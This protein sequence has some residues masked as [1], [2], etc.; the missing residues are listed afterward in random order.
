MAEERAL[1]TRVRDFLSRIPLPVRIGGT[2]LFAAAP[3]EAATTP[4][5]IT[6][7]SLGA[8]TEIVI[9][10]VKEGLIQAEGEHALA[11]TTAVLDL[12]QLS[13]ADGVE[14][15]VQTEAPRNYED[16]MRLVHRH[17]PGL[18]NP[19][20]L[21]AR[22]G[23][24]VIRAQLVE[25]DR[26]STPLGLYDLTNPGIDAAEAKRVGG[27]HDGA[28][29]A[30]RNAMADLLTSLEGKENR[31]YKDHNGHP[32]IGKGFNLDAQGAAQ[33]WA[34][35]FN[36]AAYKKAMG[37]NWR[38]PDFDKAKT[39]GYITN[40]EVRQ[41]TSHVLKEKAGRMEYILKTRYDID[42]DQLPA[43][44]RVGLWMMHYHREDYIF[45]G[46]KASGL[47][48]EIKTAL[49]ILSHPD[50]YTPGAYD[51]AR[52]DLGDVYVDQ[53]ASR[54]DAGPLLPRAL[55][56]KA[57]IAG[58]AD[59]SLNADQV[60]AAIQ[61]TYAKDAGDARAVVILGESPI[62]ASGSG[63]DLCDL[64]QGSPIDI[65]HS[66]SKD[67]MTKLYAR[68][69]GGG[70]VKIDGYR[71]AEG[72]V[73]GGATVETGGTDL[74]S[75]SGEVT[76]AADNVRTVTPTTT[77]TT[78]TRPSTAL[79]GT[80]DAYVQALLTQIDGTVGEGTKTDRDMWLRAD[81][82]SHFTRN[83]A[84]AP[85]GSNYCA[86]YVSYQLRDAVPGLVGDDAGSPLQYTVG[87]KDVRNQLKGTGFY[88]EDAPGKGTYTVKAGDLVI[89]DR[90]SS[91]TGH[92]GIVTQV[93][94][95]VIGGKTV[96]DAIIHTVEANRT[97][98][99]KRFKLGRF[100]PSSKIIGFVDTKGLIEQAMTDGK[101]AQLDTSGEAMNIAGVEA[102]GN[103]VAAGH[104]G[105]KHSLTRPAAG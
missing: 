77:L 68:D 94:S 80:A 52:R 72:K 36:D 12:Q 63:L 97:S 83:G 96:P 61:S 89:F 43:G 51:S 92:I 29:T 78:T 19:N 67:G 84:A 48:A 55:F 47:R 38:M 34:D 31:T 102:H 45:E 85:T 15:A 3:L 41:L 42:A 74:S 30:A 22:D 86:A 87:A 98:T 82:T 65:Y 60:E 100:D 103:G 33:I 105:R 73:L 81:S 59:V 21:T 37:S 16:A 64:K 6:E 44:A 7:G 88:N 93:E 17:A 27:D 8:P 49:Q 25:A 35:A 2:G 39:N 28:E 101:V 75:T 9:D 53:I 54:G 66:M 4:A 10:G 26:S 90:G 40:N 5:N 58:D 13:V 70:E 11:E 46:N 20:S 24:L 62:D 79:P 99:V 32:T 69:V 14:D 23:T 18:I 50:D 56:V 76:V 95:R 57:L 1:I 104:G 71:M 91:W